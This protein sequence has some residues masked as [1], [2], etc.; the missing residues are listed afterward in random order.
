MA[1]AD[2]LGW[3]EETRQP[4]AAP[5]AHRSHVESSGLGWPRWDPGRAPGQAHQVGAEKERVTVAQAAD[6][7]A[8][9]EPPARV[10]QALS[11]AVSRET[12]DRAPDGAA[13]EGPGRDSPSGGAAQQPAT[14]PAGQP[15][16][17][18]AN[19]PFGFAGGSHLSRFH[20]P[21][22]VRTRIRLGLVNDIVPNSK[23][24]PSSPNQRRRAIRRS[25]RRKYS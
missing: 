14:A 21:S 3:P 18:A 8:G 4:A 19:G 2:G 9:E 25:A 17:D 24:P 13:R 23:W 5:A 15:A 1:S 16:T 10:R 22:A 11:A 12:E 20:R 7:R 6:E